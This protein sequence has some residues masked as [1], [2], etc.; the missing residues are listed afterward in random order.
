MPLNFVTSGEMDVKPPQL[1]YC[2]VVYETFHTFWHTTSVAALSHSSR[3]P[4]LALRFGWLV[5]FFLGAYCT[6]K[7]VLNVYN[8]YL[9]RPY[10]T[11]I[12]AKNNPILDFPAVTVCNQNRINC[13]NLLTVM[14]KKQKENETEYKKLVDIYLLSDCGSETLH[15]DVTLGYYKE[16]FNLS[17]MP[18]EDLLK[19]DLC[20]R[21]ENI[22]SKW[23]EACKFKNSEPSQNLDKLENFDNWWQKLGCFNNLS[24]SDGNPEPTNMSEIHES[25]AVCSKTPDPQQPPTGEERE[26]NSTDYFEPQNQ[27][28]VLSNI[29]S[30]L[31]SNITDSAMDADVYEDDLKDQPFSD[32]IGSR[33]GQQSPSNKYREITNETTSN[34]TSDKIRRKRTATGFPSWPDHPDMS[35]FLKEDGF[36]DMEASEQYNH[37]M[38]FLVKYVLLPDN[39]RR[40]I[41]YAFDDLIIDCKFMGYNCTNSSLFLPYYSANYGN[42][43]TYNYNG[44]Q[45]LSLPG[46]SYSFSLIL[47][48]HEDTYLP[49]LLTDKVGV[50]LAVHRPLTLPPLDEDGA[51]FSPG[52]SSSIGLKM[53][54]YSRLEPPHGSKCSQDWSKTSYLPK[55]DG[56]SFDPTKVY[57]YATCL[58]MCA[59]RMFMDKCACAHPLLP[60]SFFYSE[61]YYGSYRLCNLTS[62]HIDSTCMRSHLISNTSYVLFVSECDCST[63][64]SQVTYSRVVSRSQWPPKTAL[65]SIHQVYNIDVLVTENMMALDVFF[66]TLVSDYIEESAQYPSIESLVSSLGGALSLYLGISIFLLMEFV[67]FLFHLAYNSILYATGRYKSPLNTP[68]P[69]QPTAKPSVTPSLPSKL[70]TDFCIT[71][72]S[73]GDLRNLRSLYGLDRMLEGVTVPSHHN[74]I[75]NLKNF[76]S[77]VFDGAFHY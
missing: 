73:V 55:F 16:D 7:D 8:N 75:D 13:Q 11:T 14:L 23:N 77:H 71:A 74:E 49:D 1:S 4:F 66:R 56:D 42:C 34:P 67:E 35:D 20:L 58:N 65:H 17:E 6:I 25:L 19:G 26:E 9:E 57:S 2:R 18:P 52:T 62:N 41:G 15:C 50:K 28:R 70:P 40:E 37:K 27:T 45:S 36:D 3:S 61:K 38:N 64:C 29:S 69:R 76:K 43:Y 10:S 51:D 54:E 33:D 72:T 47:H 60:L 22:L 32:A 12:K 31:N 46:P 24:Q 39:L 48:I 63:A 68:P 59:Q 5:L 30:I 44:D 53:S 21:C